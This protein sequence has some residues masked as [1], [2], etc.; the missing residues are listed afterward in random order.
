MCLSGDTW[1]A[2][3][4]LCAPRA[5]C[6]GYFSVS[7]VRIDVL[8][9]NGAPNWLFAGAPWECPNLT[10]KSLHSLHLRLLLP[11][12]PRLWRP[13]FPHWPLIRDK[14]DWD[15]GRWER[16]IDDEAGEAVWL[17]E[18]TRGRERTRESGVDVERE[19]EREGSRVASD[20][21]ESVSHTSKFFGS[22]L[23]LIAI[24]GYDNKLFFQVNYGYEGTPSVV[25]GGILLRT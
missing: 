20:Y 5:A 18:R 3:R 10:R 15:G 17:R 2:W 21:R 12:L 1:A 22:H 4:H 23:S 9:W 11:C 24:T 8:S 7:E 16:E 25:N 6:G 19:L 13:P 14:T